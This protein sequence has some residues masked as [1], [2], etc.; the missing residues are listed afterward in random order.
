MPH[1]VVSLRGGDDHD[2]DERCRQ[3]D[4]VGQQPVL[5]VDRREQ[6]K[7][8]AKHD[9]DVGPPRRAEADEVRDDECGGD[10]AHDHCACPL[11][12]ELAERPAR[13]GLRWSDGGQTRLAH[14]H[15]GVGP[16]DH[17]E[18][19]PAALVPSG[20]PVQVDLPLSPLVWMVAAQE[21]FAC[22]N[23]IVDV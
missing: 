15:V 19:L 20:C 1:E 6:D 16:A 11:R 23:L 10:G 22:A 17:L 3:N 5:E 2:D 14:V 12:H 13:H 7:H 9:A 8:R 21:L 4:P 18:G